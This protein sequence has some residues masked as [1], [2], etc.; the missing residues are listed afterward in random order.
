MAGSTWEGH[1][2]STPFI[3]FAMVC[4]MATTTEASD[5]ARSTGSAVQSVAGHWGLL[6]ASAVMLALAFPLPG[7]APLAH[8]ALVPAVFLAVRSDHGWRL[9]WTAYTVSFVWWLGRL[10][11]LGPVTVG[12]HV[13]LSLY[14]AIYLPAALVVIRLV[15]RRNGGVMTL[16]LPI[17][18]V[19]LEWVRATVPAGGFAWFSLGHSQGP[20]APS[21]RVGHLIQIADLFGEHGVSFLVAMTNGLIADLCSCR[22]PVQTSHRQDLKRPLAF[23]A[24]AWLLACA[25]A[26]FYGAHRIGQ[27]QA[28]DPAAQLTV[29]VIQT[30]V[31]Q[32]NKNHPTPTQMMADWRRLL[33]LTRTAA[34]HHRAPQLVVWPETMVPAGLNNAARTYYQATDSGRHLFHEQI[35]SLAG[36]LHVYLLVGAHALEDWTTVRSADGRSEFQHPNQRYNAVYLYLPDGSQATERYDKI[37]RVPFGEYIPWVERVPWLKKQFIKYL[38]PYEVDYTV[39]AGRSLAVF[40]LDHN[41]KPA[42]QQPVNTP[43]GPAAQTGHMRISTPICF[44]DAVARVTRAMVFGHHYRKRSDL[45]VNLTNDGWYAGT[46]QGPQHVQIAVFRCIENRVPMAR[47]VNTG[48][49]GFIDS[50]GR[51]GPLVTVQGRTQNVEGFAV[52][53]V[54]LDPRHTLF[55]RWGQATLAGLIA[56]SSIGLIGTMR[57]HKTTITG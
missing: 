56:A 42:I 30:N 48:V 27:V 38:S 33:D 17:V 15:H 20:Y 32:D 12:G 50:T 51:V 55:G 45:L 41:K 21:H 2:V 6:G 11:W 22:W 35:A 16:M 18:W 57:R 14:L 8:I 23:L 7:W 52:H 10:A 40:R 28:V 9:A 37:H 1:E 49:S 13:T 25:G 31:A 3:A 53:T 36:Q 43:N 29:A 44:E 26:W 4:V 46:H 47:S 39:T 24:T 19:T 5:K 54:K 34:S